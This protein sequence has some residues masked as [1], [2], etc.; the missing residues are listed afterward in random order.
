MDEAKWEQVARLFDLLISSQNPEQ[1]LSEEADDEVRLHAERLWR[2]HNRAE[3][4]EFLEEPID[5]QTAPVF[6]SGERLLDGRFRIVRMLGAGGMGEVYL[7]FDERLGEQIAIKTIPRMLAASP[8][9][10]RR[11]VAEVQNARR[12][13]HE[14]V[15]RIYELFDQGDT[16]FFT[17]EFIDG[18]LLSEMLD[19]P[20]AKSV[21]YRWSARWRRGCI[22]RT[23]PV[24]STETSSHRT[25][26]W[27]TAIRCGQ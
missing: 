26:W 5:F 22:R 18:R 2:S 21:A 16:V 27:S 7:A 13:P 14:N 15:C 24:S 17:M 8:Q 6:E 19:G 9:L 25:S 10:R 1:V 20:V 4:E 23:E 12:V 3:D 11:I